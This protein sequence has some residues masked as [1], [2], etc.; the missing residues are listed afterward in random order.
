MTPSV[1]YEPA[2]RAREYAELA[3]NTYRG[4]DH[5]CIYCYAPAAIRM[6][7]QA[8]RRPAPRNN[9]LLRKIRR[10]ADEMVRTKDK[11][12]VLFCFTCDPYQKC[13]V[14]HQITRRALE[15]LLPSGIN[16][17]VLT[18]GG[19]R[20]RRDFDL[21]ADHS[22]QVT[23]AATLTFTDETQRLKYETGTAAPTAERIQ[24]LRDA[25]ALGVKTWVSLEPVFDPAQS[26]D[27]I[28][29]THEFVDLYK[30]GV[31]N[32]MPEKKSIDWAQFG[33]D[34]VALCESLGKDTYIKD[35]LRK[36]L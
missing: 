26:L 31:V 34:A 17:T 15:I 24:C 22:D 21:F 29:Q 14:K 28:R 30:I 13:D 8:F 35:D 20:S 5:G 33:R 4:C 23:Y 1:I 32:Y 10:D 6:S 3:C 7:P 19:D 18:K 27:L 25:H 36:Y 11:R 9:D 2:G 12:S 16:V